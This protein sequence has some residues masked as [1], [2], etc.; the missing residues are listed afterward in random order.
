MAHRR[1]NMSGDE[2]LADVYAHRL[3]DVPIDCEVDTDDD[4]SG[5]GK[6]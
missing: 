2:L 4:R 1:K 6:I 5:S 3:S